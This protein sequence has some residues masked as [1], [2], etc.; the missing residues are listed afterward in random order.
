MP[1]VE[2][3][4]IVES[5]VKSMAP[6]VKRRLEPRRSI[7]SSIVSEGMAACSADRVRWTVRRAGGAGPA[8]CW[9]PLLAPAITSSGCPKGR[10]F[11]AW[12]ACGV[13]HFLFSSRNRI[14]VERRSGQ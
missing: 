14:Q 2:R 6:P 11:R 5:A 7:T 8:A 4:K 9:M 10:G 3:S 1:R 13:V 12:P